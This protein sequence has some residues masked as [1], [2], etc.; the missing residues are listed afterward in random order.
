MI[1]DACEAAARA[2]T[3]ACSQDRA[4]ENELL[5]TALADAT[6][7]ALDA[8]EAALE[9]APQPGDMDEFGRDTGRPRRKARRERRQQ[10]R[11]ALGDAPVDA[12][13]T[14][15]LAHLIVGEEG[16]RLRWHPSASTT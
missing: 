6:P 11:D 10:A 1:S 13:C 16:A 3:Q 12:Y 2:A 9:N 14:D 4:D 15:P 8:T 5:R 7:A